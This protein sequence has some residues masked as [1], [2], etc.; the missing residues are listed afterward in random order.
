MALKESG[1]KIN[2]KEN[3][4]QWKNLSDAEKKPFQDAFAS[5]R[6][7]YEQEKKDYEKLYIDHLPIAKGSS[8]SQYLQ[9]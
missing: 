8:Y 7:E 6:Q 2:L 5:Q 4:E 3:V 9:T 1:R